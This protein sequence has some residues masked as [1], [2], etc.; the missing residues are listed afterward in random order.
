MKIELR[1][2]FRRKSVSLLVTIL[3]MISLLTACS[4]GSELKSY[5]N[6]D[7]VEHTSDFYVNDF[8]GVF[9]E[10]QKKEIMDKAVAFDKEYSGIQVVITTVE[11]L[12]EAVLDYE[13]IVEDPEGNRVENAD[14]EETDPKF[15][16]EQVAYSMYSQYGIGQDDMGILIL[17]STGDREVRIETGRQMQFYI[18]DSMS[19]RILDDYGMDYF[20]NDQF[21]EGLIAVQEGVIDK[22]KENVSNDWY[23]TSKKPDVGTGS[24]VNSESEDTSNQNVATDEPN[25]EKDPTKGILWGFFGSIG[26]AFAAMIAFIRQKFKGNTEKQNLEKAKQEEIGFLKSTF[27]SELDE[28]NRVHETNMASLKSEYQRIIREKD[29][30][31]Q[32][33]RG[34]ISDTQ[35]ENSTL[36][37]QLEVVSDKYSRI[38]R[39]HPEYNFDNE[40]NSMIE[41]E[42][43]VAAKEVES[44]LNEVLAIVPD[45][46][47][48]DT[49]NR[50]LSFFDALQPEVKK[51]VTFD[52][53][54][55]QK[56]YDESVQLKKEYERAEQEKRDRAAAQ[57]A[58]DKI[59]QVYKENS[60][61]NHKTYK[62]LDGALAI[63]LGLSAAQKAFFPDNNLIEKL[64]KTHFN[65][66]VD[67][68]D[69][70]AAA[71][72]ETS[73]KNIIGCM[74]Y[75][76]ED[77]RDKL[78]RAMRFYRNLSSAQQAY[79]SDEL[80]RKLKRLISEAD[81]DHRRQERRRS[82]EAAARRRA[83][84]RSS[85]SSMSSSSR[86]NF[87]GRG[88]RP[89][90]GGASRR[91]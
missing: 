22:I 33:L 61:G 7:V 21:A 29:K 57:I 13:F 32:E 63:F 79:F 87:S 53:A 52:R 1:K 42:Y 6:L 40:V 24:I 9:S 58:Y 81:E 5:Y 70:E 73:V 90:G 31:I 76:D 4:V 78:E 20:A 34:E 65:A 36:K 10:E 2:G 48:Y 62:A 59:N 64:K 14:K 44:N 41:S 8:A 66:E 38:Q 60:Q 68:K 75:A 17:F 83:Q 56:L 12:N 82:D 3:A 43:M 11:S 88:G 47:N 30:S 67:H 49:F 84:Q 45:K 85:Y 91:F 89:S 72:A 26:A 19:G 71:K 80:L 27:Q 50:A 18:T 28:K 39:L 25:K 35:Q 37:A 69:Y 55:I 16:I 51:Y 23:A 46:D 74:S 15:T 77:D 54:A 86:S